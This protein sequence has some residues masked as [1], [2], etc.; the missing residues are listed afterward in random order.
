MNHPR[1]WRRSL[2][3]AMVPCVN[4]KMDL[5]CLR[6]RPWLGCLV[7]SALTFSKRCHISPPVSRCSTARSLPL[8]RDRQ[9][10]VRTLSRGNNS[11]RWP[12]RIPPISTRVRLLLLSNS[13]WGRRSTRLNISKMLSTNREAT[14]L[15]CIT[16]SSKHNPLKVR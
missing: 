5:P 16:K 8:A 4:L 14:T 10:T 11:N 7:K 13:R 9:A 15:R 1:R 6:A 2:T 3:A 12:R